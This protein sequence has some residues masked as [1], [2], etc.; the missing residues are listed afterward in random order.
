MQRRFL[1]LGFLGLLALSLG[2]A[3][4]SAQAQE[5]RKEEPRA[6][7]KALKLEVKDLDAIEVIIAKDESTLAEARADIQV[8]QAQLARLMLD[9]DPQLEQIRS[10]VKQ[11]LDLEL[12]IRMIQITRQI[13]VKKL[14]GDERWAVLYRFARAIQE[15]QK[16][17]RL[18]EAFDTGRLDKTEIETWNRLLSFSRRFL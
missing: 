9:K 16:S 1:S 14:L 17:G 13:A 3:P 15:A 7:L 10:V 11:S 4:L 8:L 2:R 18:K 12:K 6:I 5:S